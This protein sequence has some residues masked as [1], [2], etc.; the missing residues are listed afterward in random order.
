M[1]QLKGREER[2]IDDLVGA[3]MLFVMLF[4]W[5]GGFV[6]YLIIAAEIKNR[7]NEKNDG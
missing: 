1:D 2:M 5:G 7:K 4:L 6:L 3:A